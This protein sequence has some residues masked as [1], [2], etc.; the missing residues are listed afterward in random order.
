MNALN[1]SKL[2]RD[3]TLDPEDWEE[4]R[5]LGH[6]MVDDMLDWLQTLSERPVWQPVPEEVKTNLN[7]PIPIEGQSREKIYEDFLTLVRPYPKGNLHPRFWGWV[8]GNG[9]PFGMLAE[10]LAAGMNSNVSF[11]DQSAVYVEEQVINWCKEMLGFPATSSGILVSGGS[12]ANTVALTVARNAKADFDVRITG[13]QNPPARMVLYGSS[14]THS[15]SQKAIELLGIGSENFR[16]IPVNQDYQI[17]LEKLRDSIQADRAK[18]RKPFCVIGNAGT[19]NTGAIDDLNAL[20]DICAEENLW[21]HIDGAFGALAALSPKFRPMLKGMARADSLICCL[22]KWMYIPYE[23]SCV[24][25]RHRGEHQRSFSTS[26]SYLSRLSRGIVGGGTWFSEY[27][28]QLSREF[29]ALKVWMSI[30]EHGIKKY[31]QLIEQNIAQA[32]YLASLIQKSEALELL[33]PVALN[34]V[35]F[36]FTEDGISN[37]DLNELNKEVLMRLQESGVA[38][39]SYTT[40]SGKFGLRC[41]ITN[42]RSRREDFD[43]LIEKVLEIGRALREEGRESDNVDG[44]H[45]RSAHGMSAATKCDD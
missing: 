15:S 8:E 41:A 37:D 13:L 28:L 38:A 26:G 6:R 29:R 34:V 33:A 3:E 18:G 12:M 45:L 1:S 31:G 43:L 17:D 14:E 7:Q 10:M 19:V 20:A 44:S 40:L 4:M 21:F 24:L 5:K 11:G 42:H 27:G 22:H 9:T 30:K 25:I 35:C 32:N 36:R 2:T 39:P 16:R 23:A